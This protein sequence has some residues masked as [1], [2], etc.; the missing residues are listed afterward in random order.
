M[1]AITILLLTATLCWSV[2]AR[3]AD[4]KIIL[5]AGHPSHGPG[6]HEFNAGVQ[7]LHKCLAG[8]PGVVSQFSLNGWP[9]DPHIF[10][11]AVAVLLPLGAA[12]FPSTTLFRPWASRAHAGSPRP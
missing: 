4:K 8:Q 12:L 5:I 2:N 1:K 3:A 11:F 9:S 7:L 6:D 10:D